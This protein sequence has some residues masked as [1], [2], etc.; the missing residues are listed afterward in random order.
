MSVGIAMLVHTALDRVEQVARH[1]A[2]AGC[3]VALHVDLNVERDAHDRLV[4]AL[5]DQPMIRFCKRHRCE[6]GRWGI[7]AASQSASEMLLAEFDDLH[8][9]YLVSGSCLPLRP[10]SELVEYLAA[11]PHTDFIESATTA[12]V[13]WAKGGLQQERFTLRFPFSWKRQRALFDRYVRLQRRLG[14]QRKV[15]DGL[16]PHIGSQWWCLTRQTLAAI[17]GDPNRARY[18]RYFRKVWIPDESYFQTLVRRYSTEIESRSLTLS[19]FDH[20]GKPHVF[21]DD[22]L[23]LL[24]RSNCFVARKA[25]PHATRLYATFLNNSGPQNA[26]EPNPARIDRVFARAVEQRTRGRPGLYMQSR[27]PHR[28]AVNAPTSNPYSVF[29][30]FAELFDNF[31]DWL[32][33]STGTQVHGHLFAPDR[34]AFAGRG[35]VYNG[36]L[37]DSAAKRDYAPE[38]FLTSL[39]W[40]TRGAR[41]CLQ[42]G[43]ADRQAIAPFIAQDPNARIAVITG[44]WAI[45]LFHSDRNFAELRR[46]AAK[47][48]K[49][50][51][52][53]LAV[54]RSKEAKAQA[55]IWSLAEFME[56]P[57]EALQDIVD[58]IG[59]H[60][61]RT[62][63]EAPQMADLAGFGQFLQKL[64]N[65]GMHPHLT[66]DFPLEDPPAIR[67]KRPSKPYLV[68]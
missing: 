40:N 66:G 7:V 60:N 35:S 58:E 1:W 39:I 57:M 18:D 3:P 56:A 32:G 25:W 6:W 53:Q 42:F 61:N 34:V 47:L 50:E 29:Q 26:A 51:T 5:A 41:Q 8:H 17:L 28:G 24:R 59:Q 36:G 4:Q 23:Q 43:P 63:T 12:D 52:R 30:G 31:E 55:R 2:A 14:L 64:K 22:H 37:S 15:P 65:Q 68:Q 54:L 11:R 46:R 20:Q 67:P 48:Q 27:M 16:D 13:P 45:P 19:K 10:V 49:I 9:V 21:Y 44:A 62:L 33:R 38:T